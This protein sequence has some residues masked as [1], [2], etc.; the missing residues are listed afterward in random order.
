MAQMNTDASVLS[1]EATNFD[2][3]A[4]ELNSVIK[5]VESTGSELAGHWKGAAGSAAQQSLA[6][7]HEAGLNQTKVLSDIV[8]T[9]QQAGVQYTKAQDDAEQSLA[10][11]MNI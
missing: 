7:F 8:S 5:S 6:R 9:I 4:S 2:R 11:Q 1:A 3:I 10:S